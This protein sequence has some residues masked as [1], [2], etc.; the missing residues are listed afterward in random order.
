MKKK[1][2]QSEKK[3]LRNRKI[4]ASMNTAIKKTL[5]PD[6]LEKQKLIHN[7]IVIIAKA[8]A[9]GIIHKKNAAHKISRIMSQNN[10]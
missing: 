4:K 8:A 1:L 3:R 9:K 7:A 5:L 2:I 10:K 6:Q